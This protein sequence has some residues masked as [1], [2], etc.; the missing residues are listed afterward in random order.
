MIELAHL[1]IIH[2]LHEKGTLTEA[3]N[4][5]CLTQ[6]A[7]S[8]QIRYLEKKLE[9]KLWQK[10]G[11]GIRLTQSGEVL[12]KLAQQILPAVSQAELNLKAHAAGK[13]GHLRIGVEC[14][15]CYEWLTGVIGDCLL[16]MPDIDLDIVHQ[17]QFSGQEG[18]LNHHFDV[19]ITPDQFNNDKLVFEPLFN[20]QLVL[21]VSR[22]H[23]LSNLD[24]ITA[25]ML[26]EETLLTLPVAIERL[27]IFTRFLLPAS[28]SPIQ[29]KQIESIDI[30]M[31]LVAF[32][33]GVCVL[34]DWLAAKYQQL[35]I[36]AVPLGKSGIP[37][38]LYAVVHETEINVPYIKTFIQ[39]GLDHK[40]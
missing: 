1:R 35:P 7:L 16:K 25:N 9:L 24:N 5:L 12:L 39:Q 32:N 21:F 28:V 33:R 13:Q 11:R 36:K 27:D 8:H 37:K 2:A 26:A 6:S 20:Y 23:R 3:A 15:P 34:P 30:M 10:Q 38:T 18:L 17:F 14:Y 31:Q 40:R 22:Q 19:L 4:V 29:H